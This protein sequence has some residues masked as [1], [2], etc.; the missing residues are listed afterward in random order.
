LFFSYLGF[1]PFILIHYKFSRSFPRKTPARRRAYGTINRKTRGL[2]LD[3]KPD[4]KPDA[5][6][7]PAERDSEER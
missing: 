4:A 2:I 6:P 7:R 5:G 3:S 1:R